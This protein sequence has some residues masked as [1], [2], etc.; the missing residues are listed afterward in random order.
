MATKGFSRAVSTLTKEAG[1]ISSI[2]PSLSGKKV[3][4][5]APRYS[6]LKKQ[7]IQGKEE[8]VVKSWHRLQAS[9]QGEIT[10]LKQKGNKVIG[11]VDFLDIRNGSVPQSFVDSIRHRGVGIIR[12]VLPRTYALDLKAQ[13]KEYIAANKD[14][15]KAFPKDNPAVFELY[16]SPAQVQARAHRNMLRTQSFLTTLWQSSD[17]NS[18]I[19]TTY[20]LTYADRIRIRQPGDAK[21]ALGPHTDG[22]SVERWEDPTYAKV[23]Q[24]IFDGEWEKYDPYDARH[25]MDATMDMYNGGGAC[26]MFRLFQG[27]L[28]MSSTGPGEGTLRVCPLLRHASA[29]MLL[30]P[31]FNLENDELD[32]NSTAFPGSV[33]GAAQELSPQTHPGLDLAHTVLSIPKVEPGDF[34]AWHCDTIHAVDAEHKGKSDSSVLYIPAVAMTKGN[35]EF[36]RRQRESASAFSPPPDFP[37]AGSEGEKTYRGRMDWS[38][39]TIDAAGKRAMG[40]RGQL[41]FEILPNM[42]DGEQSVIRES[43][44]V[45]FDM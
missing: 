20:P 28:A 18:Q 12:N 36:L 31:F 1:D 35:V 30:R 43:N 39:D 22:G 33:Q 26:S 8:A 16:W 19:S 32:L 17:P 2:F 29:Y 23:Y 34:V 25:R 3:L 15:V 6:E 7:L 13:A 21:F 44:R 38:S 41:S 11:E 24:K 45:L 42:S 9:L 37:G 27:W 5:L 40:F 10:E 4:L 14:K